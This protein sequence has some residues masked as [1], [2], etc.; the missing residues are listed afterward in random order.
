MI[1]FPFL[2]YLKKALSNKQSYMPEYNELIT[3]RIFEIPPL[4]E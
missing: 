4:A 1:V 2:F 3:L